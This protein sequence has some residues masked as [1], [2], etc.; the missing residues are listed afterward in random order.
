LFLIKIG[1][2]VK[3]LISGFTTIP[4]EVMMSRAVKIRGVAMV[5]SL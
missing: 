2:A 4:G 3:T 1:I 5:V